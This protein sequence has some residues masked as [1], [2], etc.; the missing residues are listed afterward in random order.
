MNEGKDSVDRIGGTQLYMAPETLQNISPETSSH[1]PRIQQTFA[2]D[3][4]TIGV[5]QQ[6]PQIEFLLRVANGEPAALPDHYS[7]NLKALIMKM[8]IK[9]PAQRITAS[10]IIQLPEVQAKLEKK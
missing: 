9:D 7:E 2:Q 4:W 1:Q 8:L 3:I 5:D 6:G 10:E